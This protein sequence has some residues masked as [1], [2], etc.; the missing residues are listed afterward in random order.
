MQVSERAERTIVSEMTSVRKS[1]VAEQSESLRDTEKTMQAMHARMEEMHER[2][3]EMHARAAAGRQIRRARRER[4]GI[5]S[6]KRTSSRSRP[7]ARSERR[8]CGDQHRDGIQRCRRSGSHPVQVQ[9]AGARSII[10]AGPVG[11]LAA[12]AFAQRGCKVD[13]FESRPDPRTDEAVAR[14]SQRSINLALSTRGISGLRS[15]SLVGLGKYTSDGTD[16]ADLVLQE[17]VPM[18]ARMIHVVTRRASAGRKAEVREQSQLY[19]TKGECINSVDRGR[20]NNILLD[21][22]LMHPNV[23]VHFE[24]KLQSVDFDHDSRTASKKARA[25]QKQASGKSTTRASERVKL[26][27]DVHTANE[28]ASRRSVVHLA[29]FVLGCD[30]AHSSIRSAMGS[31]SRMHYTHNYIDTGY[32]ELS[33]P[34]RT[35]LGAGS[36]ARGDGGLDGKPGGHDAFELDPNHLHIWHVTRLCSSRCPTRTAASRARC[37]HRSRCSARSSRRARASWAFFDEH[38][39]DALPLIGADKLVAA[40]TSRRASALGSVQ[41]DPYHYKDRAVL[42]GDAAHAMLPFYGQGP[43]LRL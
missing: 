32:V 12:L 25:G 26:E 8:W 29:S 33:I 6:G 2:I 27:F 5:R 40:L 43:Q 7:S 18:R 20:L 19:S 4:S 34:P 15:V 41:C 36:R 28:R 16:L 23:H 39:P 11:C 3:K 31:L 30:G 37:L 24:H 10:G 9:A 14:A 42:I 22:A 13:V 1:L 35:S 38:F 17:S 21:H